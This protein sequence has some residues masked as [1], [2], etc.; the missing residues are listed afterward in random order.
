MHS[1]REPAVQHVLRVFI[2]LIRKVRGANHFE[3]SSSLTIDDEDDAV[4]PG[5]DT[6]GVGNVSI[7]RNAF[8]P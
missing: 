8:L 1:P 4:S 6:R 3:T 5:C 2:V 7:C